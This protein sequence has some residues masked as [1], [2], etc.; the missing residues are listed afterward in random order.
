MILG[1]DYAV[2]EGA[3]IQHWVR[4]VTPTSDVTDGTKVKDNTG[5]TAAAGVVTGARKK[6]SG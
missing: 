2:P 4:G 3:D 5:T 6:S 1:G